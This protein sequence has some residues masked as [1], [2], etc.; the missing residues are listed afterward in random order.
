MLCGKWRCIMRVEIMVDAVTKR[1]VEWNGVS[2]PRL[3]IMAPLV[4]ARCR[5]WCAFTCLRCNTQHT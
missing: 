2:W 4:L 3:K 1:V 5:I